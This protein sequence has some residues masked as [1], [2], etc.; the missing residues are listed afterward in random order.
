MLKAEHLQGRVIA[1]LSYFYKL[2]FINGFIFA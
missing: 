2:K 1:V